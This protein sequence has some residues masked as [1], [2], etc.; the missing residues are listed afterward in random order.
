MIYSLCVLRSRKAMIFS[1][2]N[3]ELPCF[4]SSTALYLSDFKKIQRKTGTAYIPLTLTLFGGVLARVLA[5]NENKKTADT[6]T[7]VGNPK[8]ATYVQLSFPRPNHPVTKMCNHWLVDE[9]CAG[10]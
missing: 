6:E 4:S 8:R 7:L 5:E 3:R 1:P 2:D 9:F 10:H